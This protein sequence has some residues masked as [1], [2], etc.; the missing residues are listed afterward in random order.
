MEPR[1][2]PIFRDGSMRSSSRSSCTDFI[3]NLLSLHHP[4][5]ST[6]VMFSLPG[7]GH[8]AFAPSNNNS[9]LILIW[10]PLRWQLLPPPLPPA[11]DW[12]HLAQTGVSHT[13]PPHP[14][15]WISEQHQHVFQG[16]KA[17]SYVLVGLSDVCLAIQGVR[18]DKKAGGVCLCSISHV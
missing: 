11:L 17:V 3:L 4:K 1:N 7:T 10:W 16:I 6:Y 12:Q 13:P 5:G 2:P 15:A 9:D 18:K 8:P 14:P